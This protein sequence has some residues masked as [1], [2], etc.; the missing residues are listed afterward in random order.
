MKYNDRVD[1]ADVKVTATGQIAAM[2]I[3][4]QSIFTE[5]KIYPYVKEEDLRMDLI[6][7]IRK[8]AVNQAGGTHVWKGMDD[9]EILRSANLY[10]VDRI[11]G[12]RGYNLA[13]VM[14][15]GKD[16]VILDVAPAYVTDAIVR[17]VNIDRYDDREVVKTNLVESYDILMD[18]GKKHLMDKFYLEEGEQRKSLRNTILRELVGNVLAHREF[19]SSYMAILSNIYG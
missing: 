9:L 17:K 18:F 10:G 5:K 14:L 16:D 12:E 6:P 11:T 8:L 7:K 4:K 2:Y 1:D 3:R 19:T 15:L 13:A